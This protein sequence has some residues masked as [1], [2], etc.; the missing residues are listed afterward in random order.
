MRINERIRVNTPIKKGI[1]SFVNERHSCLVYGPRSG[2]FFFLKTSF[3]LNV[4][5][6]RR[7]RWLFR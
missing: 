6:V 1:L 5:P 3:K 4:R 7:E 2:N